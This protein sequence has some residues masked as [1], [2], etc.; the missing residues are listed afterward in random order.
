MTVVMATMQ[1]KKIS[2]LPKKGDSFDVDGA[3]FD[4]QQNQIWFLDPRATCTHATRISYGGHFLVQARVQN[5]DF[6]SSQTAHV[7]HNDCSGRRRRAANAESGANL[8]S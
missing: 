7:A 5:C 3:A 6:R 4:L 2:L 8:Q 1:R